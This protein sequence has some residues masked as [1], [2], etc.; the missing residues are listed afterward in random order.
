MALDK[1]KFAHHLRTKANKQSI[2]KCARY[3]RE[4]LEA[5][6]GK[7]KG[8]PVDAK[9]WGP[10]L[11]RMGFHE[12]TVEDPDRF[13]FMKGD[14]VVIQP[15]PG[16]NSSGHI[17]AYDGKIWISDFKQRDFWSGGGYRRNKPSHAFYRH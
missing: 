11:L 8:H 6:G 13:Q 3:V 5:G 12:M 16:G 14:I 15:Y 17:A 1:E 4:A 9:D 2:S 7:T 10:T